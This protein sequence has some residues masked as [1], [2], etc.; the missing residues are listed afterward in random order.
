VATNSESIVAATAAEELDGYLGDGRENDNS[1]FAG[2]G[3]LNK[4]A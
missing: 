3:S 1:S 2:N 4:R